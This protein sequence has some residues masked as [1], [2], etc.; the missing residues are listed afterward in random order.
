MS[1][2]L[3]GF[4][5]DV[6]HT[7]LKNI[8]I[9]LALA[10]VFTF[11]TTFWACNPGVPWWRKKDAITDICY[12]FFIPV[13]A[14]YFRI[15]LLIAGAAVLFHITTAD[16]LI[17]FYENG[18]GPLASLPL[19]AQMIIF[20]VGE[21]FITY[22]TH[23]WFHGKQLWKYHAVH[24]STEELE[25][26]SAARFHPI[27]IFF[28]TVVADVALL[29]A[30]ISPNVFVVLGPITIAHSAFV[31]ANLDWNLGPF[32]YVIASP[33]F[34]RWHHTLPDRGGEKN[35]AATFP[36]LDLIFGTFYMPVG[37]RPDRYGI[38]DREFPAG[39]GAQLMYPFTRRATDFA[40][41]VK[42]ASPPPA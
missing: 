33:I 4:I 12:W 37:E 27:N 21:D 29:I 8:P 16:G 39:F 2:E 34:H 40:D 22:W 17:A 24:H 25:W 13:M 5:A 30:G 36:V 38:D 35:F 18:H 19:A 11:L 7:F 42:Q 32:K 31:H 9:S 1:Q 14:R 20:L 41:I 15:G 28:G 6:G 3:L 23:R 26:I 10:A